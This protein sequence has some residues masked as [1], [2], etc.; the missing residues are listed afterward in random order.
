MPAKK[1]LLLSVSEAARVFSLLG[2]IS[3]LRLLRQYG[4]EAKYKVGNGGGR[5]SR[6]DEM[7]AAV[8]RAKLTRMVSEANK[9]KPVAPPASP[10]NVGLSISNWDVR[11]GASAHE[12]GR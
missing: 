9:V 11:G 2:D 3:R 10:P 1:P 5:N 4:W 6:L 12:R 7:Q 8:L